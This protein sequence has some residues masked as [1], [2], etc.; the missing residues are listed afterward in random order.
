LHPPK[1]Q[2]QKRKKE[3][4]K[5]HSIIA[6]LISTFHSFSLFHPNPVHRHPLDE[7]G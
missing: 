3:K 4:E 5:P 2:T 7:R 6:L 1:E